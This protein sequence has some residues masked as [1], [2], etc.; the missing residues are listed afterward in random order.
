MT[1]ELF[2]MAFCCELRLYAFTS[3]SDD[4]Y[5]NSFRKSEIS[6]TKSSISYITYYGF[7]SLNQTLLIVENVLLSRL[8]DVLFIS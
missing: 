6:D 8:F 1:D 7:R 4:Y 2:L 3:K 5:K